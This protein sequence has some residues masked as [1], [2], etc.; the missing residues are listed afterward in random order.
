M[1]YP[2]S[3]IELKWQEYW[4]S[5]E[6][7]RVKADLS[8][9]KYFVMDM[10]A[11]PS[12]EGLHMGHVHYA[13]ADIIMRK[14]RMEGMNVLHPTGWDAF[15]LPAE[16]YAVRNK[17][18]PRI[19]T[20][21]NIATFRRQLQS[22]GL[23]F[24]WSREINTADPNYF[25]WT[26][27]IFLKIFNSYFD[28]EENKAKP[29]DEL[30]RRI[31]S[32]GTQNIPC[33]AQKTRE[34]T[35]AE[36]KRATNKERAD[37]LATCRLAYIAEAPVN[38]CPEL[39]TVLANEEV[40]EQEEK[41]FTVVRRNMRQ[42][43][44]RITAFAERLLHDLETLDWPASTI[45]MQRNWIGR[46]EGA[47]IAFRVAMGIPSSEEYIIR[48]FTT[49]PD[50]LFGATYIVV[51]PEHPLVAK[52][53]TK[54]HRDSVENYIEEVRRKSD[55]E[56][57]DLSREKTGVFTGAYANNPATGQ[58][59][60]IWIADYVLM[61]YGTGA[62]MAVP[63]HDERDF[64]FAQA[65]GLPI[66]RVVQA[67][68]VEE[69]E[70]IVK[71]YT[72]EGIA[73]NS[74]F[75]S[76]LTTSDAK[77]KTIEWLETQKLGHRAIKYKL[78]DWLFSRQRFWGDPFPIIFV[79]EGDGEYPKALS[80]KMLPVVL[81]EVES[82]KPSGT[83]E[84]P[85]A[86]IPEWVNTTDPETGHP[87]RRETNTMPQWA[88][89]SWYYLR[90]LDPSNERE[91][92]S[93]ENEKYWMPVDLYIGG[94]EHAV[95][96]LLYSRF[97]H[98][99]LF[100]LG[101][102]ST[103]EPFQRMVHQGIVLGENGVKMSKSLGNVVNPDGFISKFGADTL[104]TYYMF[105]GP[106]DAMKPWDSQGIIGVYRF[107]NRVWRVAVGEDNVTDT[108]R[109]TDI[110]PSKS[111]ERTLH[112]TIRKVTEDIDALRF[113]T[114][115]SAMM[116]L[117][118]AIEAEQEGVPRIVYEMLIKLISP[119]TPHLA[120]EL[121]QRLGNH[122]SI[123]QSSWPQY[124]ESKT[125]EDTVTIILQVNGKMRDKLDVPRGMAQQD[126]ERFAR[127][128]EKVTRHIDGKQVR[129]VIVVQ[130]K[131]VNMVVV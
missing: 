49:R 15:G 123:F 4:R 41:G 99:V 18:H 126:L 81:P 108:S 122:D 116:I 106:F 63:G 29:I 67:S 111:L 68:G 7:F 13:A 113:N 103:K 45:E 56:R 59:I 110:A 77:Q 47:E 62:I 52:I 2:F 75:I 30:I 48:V 127:E 54:E 69:S 58:P 33:N 23:G 57:V 40:S 85:L 93:K 74:G 83:G 25:K 87:A 114:A 61:T 9:P 60:P 88:G 39:G 10:F 101:I 42:W 72:E 121:W 3:E 1:P 105:L 130:D 8:K 32:Q 43:M 90:Y 64:E 65:F 131:L 53:T 70:P 80:D 120:E 86:T 78:R 98:K 38:W 44:L 129:K 11:Y 22:L 27:W 91:L 92:V 104:R 119:F 20:E 94:A 28:A 125:I 36:W 97:W 46:S 21:Q 34:Y 73:V 115:V 76:G 79:D 112:Q 5:H 117:Q 107:L 16:Q 24:D 37:F 51:A 66:V 118:N 19:T 102:V 35:P 96:H 109:L 26:Q 55:L 14:K 100:D 89:S 84:S 31:E 128:S 95:T 6:T 12:G 50:T 82:Y 124:N 17:L 71:A